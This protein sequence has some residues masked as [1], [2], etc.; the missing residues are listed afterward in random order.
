ME[1]V[2]EIN[3]NAKGLMCLESRVF[4][5]NLKN[6]SAYPF[7]CRYFEQCVHQTALSVGVP[8]QWPTSSLSFGK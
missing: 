8:V 5:F 4:D 2:S 7:L 1:L 3:F 6:Q